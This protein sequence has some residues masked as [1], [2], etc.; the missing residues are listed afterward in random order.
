MTKAEEVKVNMIRVEDKE[1]FELIHS[2]RGMRPG[3]QKLE[4]AETAMRRKFLEV[5]LM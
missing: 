1:M 2:W 4:S 3:E 5:G